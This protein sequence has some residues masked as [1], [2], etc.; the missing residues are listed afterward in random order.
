MMTRVPFLKYWTTVFVIMKTDLSG[1][2]TALFVVIARVLRDLAGD[3]DQG[4]QK[5]LT[6]PKHRKQIGVA[7]IATA[8]LLSAC[9]G[10]GGDA[11]APT[12]PATPAP[13]PVTGDDGL[14]KPSEGPVTLRLWFGRDQFIPDDA[15]ASFRAEYPNITLE[16]DTIPLEQAAADFIRTYNAGAAP[17]LVQI[18]AGT[19]GILSERGML[20]DIAPIVDTWRAED[21]DLYN[22]MAPITWQM[23]EYNGTQHGMALHHGPYWFTYRNDVLEEIGAA[24]PTN[25]G[26]VLEVGR[27]VRQKRP[28]MYGYVLRASSAQVPV[29]AIGRF[30][31][32]GGEFDETGVM[33]IDSEVGYEWLKFHQT[34]MRDDISHPE[35]LSW[36]SGEFRAAFI[37]G[38]GAMASVGMNIYPEIQESLEY[39]TQWEVSTAPMP[40]TG[41]EENARHIAGGW[42]YW[43]SSAT[44]HPY[45]M[46]LVLRYLAD[47]DQSL[48]VAK[49]YQPVTNTLVMASPDYLTVAPWAP[50][51]MEQWADIEPR[52]SHFNQVGMFPIIQDAHQWAIANPNATDEEVREYAAQIQTRLN[53]VVG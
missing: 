47:F 20:L 45:E 2:E 4:E 38:Q 11:A 3:D 48:S 15:F 40:L 50:K 42:P 41:H 36:G 12:A 27:L 52:P 39:G 16:I 46:G 5:V 9:G 32:M 7:I 51:I 1:G 35:T 17:D 37:S 10:G 34:L 44:K 13:G 53:R 25:W 29:W 14:V 31:A 26:E 49:R 28:D 43:V 30:S 22:A 33:Q 24:V 21:P 19:I 23:A 18:E 8:L 6:N